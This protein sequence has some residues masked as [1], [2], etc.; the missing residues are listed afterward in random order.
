MPPRL[1]EAFQTRRNVDAVA[2]DI[3]TI[4]NDVADIDADPQ[5]GTSI[6]RHL[7]IARDHA[8]LD[9]HRAMNRIDNADE[10]DQHA[11]AS[12][13]DDPPAIL[14]DPRIDQ[15]AAMQLQLRERSLFI[16]THHPA[17]ADDIGRQDGRESPFRPLCQVP[18]PR[19]S[20]IVSRIARS[21]V[22]GVGALG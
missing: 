2:V 8:T 18:S 9:V 4:D 20:K 6:A 13:L 16:D 17:V 7:G 22:R 14:G 5:L 19:G 15:L 10:L 21:A 11:V 1:G 12:R 3:A